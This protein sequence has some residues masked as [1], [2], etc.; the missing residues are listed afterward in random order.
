MITRREVL[1]GVTSLGVVA[2]SSPAIPALYFADDKYTFPIL[3]C[4]TWNKNHRFYSHDTV[5]K[6]IDEFNKRIETSGPIMG[7]IAP[8]ANQTIELSKV[9][10]V[11]TELS[12]GVYW[13]YA[14]IKLLNTPNG[15]VLHSLMAEPN[16][17]VGFA[18]RGL[19]TVTE[20]GVVEEYSILAVDVI[21][22]TKRA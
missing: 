10:H 20:N 12:M 18:P 11:V 9:S 4:D 6:A 17:T 3:K 16:N 2:A 15:T 8:S 1:L 22:I 19:G 21:D 7:E 5:A 13:A 14:T